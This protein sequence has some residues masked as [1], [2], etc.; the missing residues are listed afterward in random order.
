MDGMTTDSKLLAQDDID[1]LLGEAGLEGGYETDKSKNGKNQTKKRS[2][3]RFSSTTDNEVRE[4]LTSLF[5]KAFLEREDD[6]KVIWNASGVIPMATGLNVKIQGIDYASLGIIHDKHLVVK[7]EGE[8]NQS[9][10]Q[11]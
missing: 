8:S 2:P 9:D 6:I 10:L 5:N 3:V 7:I 1:A 11:S 4:I